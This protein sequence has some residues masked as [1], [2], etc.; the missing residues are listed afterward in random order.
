MTINYIFLKCKQT[1]I[2]LLVFLFFFGLKISMAANEENIYRLGPRDIISLKIY[3]GGELEHEVELAVSEDGYVNIPFLGQIM[4][5]DKSTN[6]L[7]SYVAELLGKDFFVDPVVN[8]NIKNY[9]SRRFYITGAV[10]SPGL[11]IMT[12]EPTVMKLIALAGGVL[13]NR[14]DMAY[15]LR[16]KIAPDES[17]E[18]IAINIRELL[19]EGNLSYNYKLQTGDMIY[20]PSD[21]E[22][23]ISESK[24]Y[25]EGRVKSAGVFEYQ[26]GMTALNA[27][28]LAGGFSKFA[29]PN[30]TIVVRS[31]PEGQESI[32]I[33]LDAVKTGKIS[34]IE[35]QP[36][37]LVH[38]PHSW[39]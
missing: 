28:I 19:D 35:L 34:D 21:K 17:N 29:A 5:N 22:E 27:C 1:S 10:K 6:Q 9:Q 13:P 14:G 37:D 3:V 30:R 18:P 15:I 39:F 8:I 25:V 33:D 11:H 38:V 16:D 12:S 2:I 26:P 23:E 7:E 36:G 32:K 24:I 31:T 4:A 20:I